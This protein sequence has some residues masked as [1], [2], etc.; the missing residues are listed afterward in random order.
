MRICWTGDNADEIVLNACFVSGD[1][2]HIDVNDDDVLTLNHR[3]E[4]LSVRPG[5]WIVWMTTNGGWFANWGSDGCEVEQKK[6]I[7]GGRLI[8]DNFMIA[9]PLLDKLAK[10]R[11]PW[12]RKLWDRLV[13]C[14]SL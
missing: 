9:K 11:R 5:E 3:G 6:S 1:S 14:V 12:W 4:P 7:I 8:V 10:N 2:V 13:D